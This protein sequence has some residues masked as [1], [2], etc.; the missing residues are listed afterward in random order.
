MNLQENI[1]KILREEVR[2][3]KLDEQTTKRPENTTFRTNRMFSLVSDSFYNNKSTDLQIPNGT[4]WT[5]HQSGNWSNG[6]VEN[7]QWWVSVDERVPGDD[8]NKITYST[9]FYCAGKNQNRFWYA[10]DKSWFIDETK[11]LSNYILKNICFKAYQDYWAIENQDKWNEQ[12]RK[13]DEKDADKNSPYVDDKGN[14]V[15]YHKSTEFKRTQQ[16][17]MAN[18]LDIRLKPVTTP[19]NAN[20]H[21][22]LVALGN[23]RYIVNNHQQHFNVNW[24]CSQIGL[25]NVIMKVPEK[26]KR[27]S[28]FDDKMIANVQN[29]NS[30]FYYQIVKKVEPPY[31]NFFLHDFYFNFGHLENDINLNYESTKTWYFPVGVLNFMAMYY[32]STFTNQIV[33]KIKTSPKPACLTGGITTDNIK[34]VLSVLSFASAFIPVVGPFIAAGIGLAEAGVAYSQGNKEEAIIGFIFS[35]IPLAAEIP[36]LKNVG[37][38]VMK[39]IGTKVVS[40][41]P[42]SAYENKVVSYIAKNKTA[43]EEVTNKWLANNSKNETVQHIIRTTKDK[44]EE[45]LENKVKEKAGVSIPLST[46]GAKRLA[47]NQIKTTATN[48]LKK[49]M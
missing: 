7:A 37:Q 46:S 4:Q 16:T 35:A 9:I 49:V 42:L 8:T 6:K 34:T 22:N 44:G 32:G 11:I 26:N 21:F 2:R 23:I 18:G 25:N 43:V 36:G 13:N 39:Q 20:H 5:A 31:I 15:V 28:K 12:K 30:P 45:W 47:Q 3:K 41:I 17:L 10:P 33:N 48:Q 29:L 38:A 24:S 40:K 14:H 1:K 27:F 19:K